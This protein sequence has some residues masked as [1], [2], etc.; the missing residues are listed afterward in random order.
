MSHHIY[1]IHAVTALLTFKPDSV[2]R[3]IVQ[4]GRDDTEVLRC[5]E[6]AKQ[7]GIATQSSPRHDIDKLTGDKAVHQ[8]IVAICSHLPTYSE[9]DI[10]GIMTAADKPRLVLILDGIQDPHNLGACLRVANALGCCAVIAPKRNSVGLT[11]AAIKVS[12]GA[13]FSTPFIQVTNL[14]RSMRQLQELGIWLVGGSA[15]ADTELKEIDMKGDIGIVM[16]AEGF[17]LRALTAKTCDFLAKIPMIGTVESL[18]VSVAT[19]ITLY[20]AYR[21]REDLHTTDLPSTMD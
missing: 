20:E 18:N 9:Q 1:G 13:A 17:G 3:L 5:L 8:G 15:E 2:D 19:G 12:T 7:A 10:E 21:Q 6:L 11:N 4:T 14:A 16:G